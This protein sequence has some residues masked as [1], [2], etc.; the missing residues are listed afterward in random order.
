ME[1]KHKK[2]NIVAVDATGYYN[3]TKK[4]S[5]YIFQVSKPDI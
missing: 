2:I 3:Y 4:V 1:K 5:D